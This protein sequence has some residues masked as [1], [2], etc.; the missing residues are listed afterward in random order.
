MVYYSACLL[1]KAYLKTKA[2]VVQ[3]HHALQRELYADAGL[4]PVASDYRFLEERSRDARYEGR[5]F[6]NAEIRKDII[7]A[8]D[9]VV[10]KIRSLLGTKKITVPAFD[11]TQYFRGS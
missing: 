1:I 6:T 4:S 5:R 2:T 10:A 9:D 11:L 8:F 3:D 7:P